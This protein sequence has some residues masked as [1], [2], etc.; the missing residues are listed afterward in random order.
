MGITNRTET[1]TKCLEMLVKIVFRDNK[2]N[3]SICRSWLE[4]FLSDQLFPLLPTVLL[5]FKFLVEE[6]LGLK[7]TG[8][9]LSSFLLLVSCHCYAVFCL[10][11]GFLFIVIAWLET[12]RFSVCTCSWLQASLNVSTASSVPHSELSL[13]STVLN[14]EAK[15]VCKESWR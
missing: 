12:R 9:L 15:M 7:L 6:S 4:T 10:D 1:N 5:I 8:L 3:V 11:F 14:K 13:N 2:S